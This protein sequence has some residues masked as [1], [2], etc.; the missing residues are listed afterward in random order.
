MFR[1]LLRLLHQTQQCAD[2]LGVSIGKVRLF[3]NIIAEV[4]QFQPFGLARFFQP[5]E[6]PVALKN[7]LP[8]FALIKLPEQI[9]ISRRSGEPPITVDPAAGPS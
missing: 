3:A 1:G 5:D 7:G 9:P 8:E 6:F 2:F 4:I